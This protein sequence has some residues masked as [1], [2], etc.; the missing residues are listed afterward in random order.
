MP[1]VMMPFENPTLKLADT[2]AGLTAGTAFECQLTTAE[3]LATANLVQV[4]QTPCQPASQVPGRETWSLHLIFMQDWAA[5]GGGL[6]GYAKANRGQRKWFEL[7]ADKD[8]TPAG[9][10]VIATGEVWI[11]SG[12]LGGV[13]SAAPLKSDV[14]WPC[15][16]E[17]AITTPAALPLADAELADTDAA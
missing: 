9:D 8:V 7:V 16:T 11:G 12:G 17:P 3:L 10:Q 15:P 14:T 1:T 5:P 4:E 6:S 2:E 13:V